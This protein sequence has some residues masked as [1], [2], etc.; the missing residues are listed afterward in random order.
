VGG[1]AIAQRGGSGW[2]QQAP[3]EAGC[4]EVG[5][6]AVRVTTMDNPYQVNGIIT[7]A[8]I[9]RLRVLSAGDPHPG[10]C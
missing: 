8:D 2:A 4:V 1:R 9:V 5:L 10:V 6:R 7:G 3:G